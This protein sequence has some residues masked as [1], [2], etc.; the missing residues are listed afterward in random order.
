MTAQSKVYSGKRGRF[1]N[2]VEVRE[3]GS[4]ITRPLELRLDLFNHSPTGFEW[5]MAAPARRNWRLRSSPITSATMRRPCA[6]TR[7]S[8]GRS[9]RSSI[10]PRGGCRRG[11]STAGSVNGQARVDRYADDRARHLALVIRADG[12]EEV[13]KPPPSTRCGEPWAPPPSLPWPPSSFPSGHLPGRRSRTQQTPAAT[14]L[15]R[16]RERLRLPSASGRCGFCE[17]TFAGTRGSDGDAPIPDLPA[18]DP[19]LRGN[20]DWMRPD[21]IYKG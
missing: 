14:L 9:S 11:T 20:F 4:L 10:A 3:R 1:S 18:L 7:S 19:D 21:P 6:C 12:T 5:A 2:A 15:V 13:R 8:N 17:G 16:K